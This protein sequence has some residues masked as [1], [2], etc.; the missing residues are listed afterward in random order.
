MEEKIMKKLI[1]ALL[2]CMGLTGFA[3][4]DLVVGYGFD[5]DLSDG[6]DNGYDGIAVGTLAFSSDVPPDKSGQSLL[7]DGTNHVE[8]PI[9]AVNPFDGSGD[10]SIV[11]WFKPTAPGVLISSARDTT[12]DNHSMALYSLPDDGEIV[13]DNFWIDAVWGVVPDNDWHHVAVTY[14]ALDETI[15]MYIDG[16]FGEES[17][18]NPDIPD[19]IEDT[20][21]IGNSLNT[22]FPAGEGG[23]EG[24][25][26]NLKDVGIFNHTLTEEEILVVMDEGFG[27]GGPVAKNPVP[28]NN[29]IY[30]PLD[31]DLSWDPPADE[32]IGITYDVYFGTEPNELLPEWYGNNQIAAGISETTVLNSVFGPLDYETQ[33]YWRVDTWDPN[34]GV[35]QLYEGREWTFRTA[36]EWVVIVGQPEDIVVPEGQDAEF[37]VAAVNDETYQ[38]YYSST[39]DGAGTILSGET[40]D[41]LAITNV[42]LAD[43]GYYYCEV[44]NAAMPDATSERARLLTERIMAHWKLDRNLDDEVGTSDGTSPAKLTYS[45]NGIDGN[46]AQIEAPDGYIVIDNN[47]GTFPGVTVSAWINPTDIAGWHTIIDTLHTGDNNVSLFQE[48]DLLMGEVLNSGWVEGTGI[49]AGAWQHAALVCN[50]ADEVLQLYLNGELIAEDDAD[51]DV[52]VQAGPLTMGAY[53]DNTDPNNPTPIDHLVGLL[54]DVRIYNYALSCVQ[55]ASLYTADGFM[56]GEEVCCGDYDTDLSGPED[57]PDCRVDIYDLVAFVKDWWLECNI[58]PDCAFELP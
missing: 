22:E 41:T 37:T 51:P 28:A 38:W 58:V 7:L 23:F 56:S 32:I 40:T 2:L 31:T 18:F 16:E 29:E 21:L 45:N 39:P 6:S 11:A 54:D 10:F 3:Y 46:A 57:V 47:I 4:A 20:V 42:Q 5:G 15:T 35:P 12:P 55:V 34:D 14:I 33:Y 26:G 36:P 49:V 27:P 24:W 9:N 17:F 19:I 1:L 30:A 53:V 48:D 25:I 50:T 43:E 13:Y 8:V 44:M 52:W